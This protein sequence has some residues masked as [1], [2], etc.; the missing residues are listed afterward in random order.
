MN[1]RIQKNRLHLASLGSF[2]L[3]LPLGIITIYILGG[4]PEHHLRL[5][6]II[7]SIVL[8][9]RTITIETGIRRKLSRWELVLEEKATRISKKYF[10]ICATDLS[11][12]PPS[13]TKNEPN[14]AAH[15]ER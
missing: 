2:L 4:N 1:S 13:T 11:A 6:I 8:I 15:H 14:Q 7:F 5:P 3:G 10:G 12:E 9:M